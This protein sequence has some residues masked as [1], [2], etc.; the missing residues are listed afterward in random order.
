MQFEKQFFSIETIK[1]SL[2]KFADAAGFEIT[3]D[4][5]NIY[6]NIFKSDLSNHDTEELENSIRTEVLDQDLRDIV[7]NETKDVRRLILANAFS[8][9][10]LLED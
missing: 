2:Y 6:I 5:N 8:N 10:T 7:A 1:K 9:T 4:E 3:S